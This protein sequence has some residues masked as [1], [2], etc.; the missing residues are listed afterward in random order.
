MAPAGMTGRVPQRHRLHIDVQSVEAGEDRDVHEGAPAPSNGSSPRCRKLS[1]CEAGVA[2]GR[3][4]FASGRSMKTIED[5]IRWLGN[6][7]E[8]SDEA[9]K[10]K[11]IE[12][13]QVLGA[14]AEM[15]RIRNQQL[16][17]ALNNP[18]FED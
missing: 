14:H 1:P 9:S 2:T 5:V 6:D 18:I 10:D 3:S 8:W 13:V 11:A 7:V 16:A 4:R 15:A 17:E 12:A